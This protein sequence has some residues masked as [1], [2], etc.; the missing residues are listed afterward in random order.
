MRR[1]FAVLFALLVITIVFA[2]SHASSRGAK[3]PSELQ[4]AFRLP[5][6]NGWTYVHLQGTPHEIGFQN[7]YL[8][9]PEIEDTL[10]VVM[11]E[12]KHDYKK[13]WSFFRDAAQMMMWPHTE[14][15]YRD[16]L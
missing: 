3:A 15:E 7:G 10:K 6:K 8:L 4:G 5:E 16:E 12:T 13:D 9:A 11:L 2:I 1:R 14:Q